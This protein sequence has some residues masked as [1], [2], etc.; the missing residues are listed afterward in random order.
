MVFS[1]GF[2]QR[3]EKLNKN[4]FARML[5]TEGEPKD[6]NIHGLFFWR[7]QKLAFEVS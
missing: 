6:Y 4:A 3:L 2:F 5:V 7:T 1:S